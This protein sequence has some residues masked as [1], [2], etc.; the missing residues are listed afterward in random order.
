MTAHRLT[1][2]FTA[3][4]VAIV[5]AS[6]NGMRS[7]NAI[8]AMSRT[9]VRLHLVNRRGEAVLGRPT[10]RSLTDLAEAGVS[11]DAAM[12]FTNAAAAVQ[13]AAE[14]AATGVGGVIVNA[15]GFAEA[16]GDG[17]RLQ[18]QL[19]ESAGAMPVLGPNC[20]GLVSPALGLH[21]AGSPP[22]LPIEAG[23]LA[24]VTHSGATMM[25]MG[26]A[27]VERRIGFR[28]LVSTGNEAAVD[29]AEVIDYLATDKSITAICLLIE[30]I[31]NPRA[32]WQAVDHAIAH[33]K[34]VLALKN[35]RSAR[36]QAIA[37]SHT[38][39][40]AG[41]AWI[42]EAALRQHGVII[43]NDLVDLADR[44]VLF[45]Q[46][47]RTKWNA[48]D[49]LAVVSGSG[50]YVTMASDVSAE[51]GQQLPALEELQPRI[52]QIV[53]E[54]TVV[55]PLDLTGAAM[56]N[57]DIMAGALSA[58]VD[59]PE[60]DTVLIQ[61]A[62]VDGGEEALNAFAGPALEVA[63]TTEKLLIVGSIEGGAIGKGLDPY[64]ERGIAVTRGLR[65]CIRALRSM[66]DFVS[67]V[68]RKPGSQRSVDAL[69]E[70]DGVI[71]HPAAGRMLGFEATMKLLSRY[72]VPVAPYHMLASDAPI[73]PSQIPFPGPYVVKLADVPH[74]SDIGAVRVNVSSQ[75]LPQ[76]VGELRDLADAKAESPLVAIQPLYA[77][78]SE[79]LVGVNG[80]N[81]L[82]PFV[83]LGL[84]GVFVEILRKAGGR[85][86]PIGSRDAA[87]LIEEINVGGVLDGPRGTRAWPRDILTDLLTGIGDL[88]LAAGDWLE[89]LDINPLALTEHGV[90]AVDGLILL[91]PTTTDHLDATAENHQ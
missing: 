43:A 50:G 11:I 28:Y 57:P 39:A 3:R 30:T 16:G 81:E 13:V 31:R 71:E 75:E 89:S 90:V 68:P 53:P 40:V 12:L 10:A 20:N 38:G 41:E 27:G 74:R 88:A 78:H 2:L 15:G 82:G 8:E 25:P 52:N 17:V 4:D 72:G 22:N 46:V 6:E 45:E 7:R 76:V 19:I 37:K 61:S 35:G 91:R 69:P 29:M 54:A 36:G 59:S 67:F 24:F 87:A 73:V 85:L 51:E 1:R 5:G 56:T 26:I 66:S 80:T 14:A 86:A 60:V 44:A 32:F 23:G 77:I 33:G 48:A 55:N 18:A 65:A 9:G 34:P 70:P 84:G 63:P 21:L 62:V 79:L 64:L 42:Y 58:F 49:G 47:P 83:V